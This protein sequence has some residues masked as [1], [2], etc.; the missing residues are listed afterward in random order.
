LIRV[1]AN[2]LDNAIKYCPPGSTVSIIVKHV[3]D[4]VELA[5]LDD[6]PGVPAA[7]RADLLKPRVRGAAASGP[8][9]GL[10]LA[11]VSAVAAR[12]AAQLRL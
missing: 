5:V 11:L 6:G 1:V 7:A 4:S 8:G 12:H 9:L 10:G 3:E 2:L